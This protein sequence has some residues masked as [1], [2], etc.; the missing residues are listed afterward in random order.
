MILQLEIWNQ[1]ILGYFLY[2]LILK[3]CTYVLTSIFHIYKKT[4]PFF[5]WKGKEQ[6][7]HKINIHRITWQP[8]SSRSRCTP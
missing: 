1:I 3:E 8:L 6:K 5:Y 4:P 7:I 2:V